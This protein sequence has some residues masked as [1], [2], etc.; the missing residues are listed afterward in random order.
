MRKDNLINVLKKKE[1][2]DNVIFAFDTVDRE[3][4]VPD[5]LKLYSYD[6]I[7]IPISEGSSISQP[8]TT[9][10]L[11][12]LL[13]IKEDDKLLEIGSGTGY[14]AAL[15]SKMT[16]NNV[17]AVEINMN[18]A[19]S[20]AKTLA[21]T[22]PNVKVLCVDGSRGLQSQAPFDKILISAAAN[23]L[24]TLY[25]LFS[26]LNEGGIIV[27]PVKDKIIKIKKIKNAMEKQEFEGFSF[28]PLID[29]K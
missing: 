13:E 9:A 14:T 2:K 17:F 19:T 7:P 4:F 11:L 22:C 24:A 18:L 21:E 27:S 8:S 20:S 5:H 16:K 23:D 1:F 15:L 26:Q 6:D 29:K 10:F 3:L 28:V 12:T 25:N